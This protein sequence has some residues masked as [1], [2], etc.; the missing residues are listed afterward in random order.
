M[1]SLS[2][3]DALPISMGERPAVEDAGGKLR[4]R[5]L[6]RGLLG[7]RGERGEAKDSD[8]EPGDAC[9]PKHLSPHRPPP[10]MR[11]ARTAAHLTPIRALRTPP[12][13]CG[14]YTPRIA[15]SDPF[16]PVRRS[17]QPRR[18]ELRA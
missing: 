3:H 10:W 14:H 9:N 13:R 15:A 4:P 6:L 8:R 11:P 17:R 12:W 16:R 2:L 5:I 18:V 7:E 1:Y